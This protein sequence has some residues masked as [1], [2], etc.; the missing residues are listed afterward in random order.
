MSTEFSINAFAAMRGGEP[1]RPYRYAHGD[2]APG[3]VA[4]A[5]SHCGL[6][7]SDVHLLD[8]DWNVTSYP[9]VPGHE[10]IGTIVATGSEVAGSRVGVGWLA[11]SCMRCPQCI[12]GNE[13]LCRQSKATCVGRH[14]GYASQVCVDDRFAMPVP[15]DLPSEFAAPLL[16]AGITVFAP[17]ARADLKA[18]CRVGVIGLG[19]LGHLAVQYA[20][21]M[22]CTVSVFSTSPAK[23]EEARRFGAD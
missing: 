10:I 4:I 20:R 12:G 15:D 21:A 22:G 1:L 11:G 5:I 8:N 16:C 13:N 9:F 6:C 17:L 18:H 2:L 14:G 19:G 23:A 7:H 3:E